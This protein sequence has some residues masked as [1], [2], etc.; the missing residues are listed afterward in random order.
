M[1]IDNKYGKVT[2]EKG[3]IGEDEP[4]FVFRARD[5]MLPDV[6]EDYWWYCQDA[7]SPEHHIDSIKNAKVEIEKWQ[8]QNETQVPQS[9][10]L[11]P[12]AE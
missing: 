11:A 9:A 7:G 1:G 6:L 3:T 12:E 8:E 4:V 5:K 2:F 10:S